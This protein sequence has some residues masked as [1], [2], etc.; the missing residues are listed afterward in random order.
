METVNKETY[1]SQFSNEFEEKQ[2]AVVGK[3]VL[4]LAHVELSREQDS[5]YI[6]ELGCGTGLYTE[7]LQPIAEKV[8]ATDFSDEMIELAKKKRGDLKNVVFEKADALNLHYED[9]SFDTVFMANLIHIIGNADRVIKESKRVL[10]KGG[11]LI[12]TSFAINDMSFF[13]RLKMGMRYLKIFGKPSKEATLEKTTHKSIEN[14]LINNGLQ[15]SKSLLL[16]EQYK[17]FYIKARKL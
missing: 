15:I 3:K 7:T 16:G 10:K 4:S 6:L 2:S 12:I 9:E 11:S 8:L 5:G 1:W 17:I 13:N 14:L